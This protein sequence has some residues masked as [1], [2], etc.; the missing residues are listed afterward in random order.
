LLEPHGFVTVEVVHVGKDGVE[1]GLGVCAADI[2]SLDQNGRPRPDDWEVT[3]SSAVICQW[4]CSF[5]PS[6]LAKQLPESKRMVLE[7]E[8]AN[9]SGVVQVVDFM[10]PRRHHPLG[11]G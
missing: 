6:S 1:S 7:T 10:P 3:G 11:G 8:I 2:T 9:S 4:P 5:S